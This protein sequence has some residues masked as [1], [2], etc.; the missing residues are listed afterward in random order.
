[1]TVFPVVLGTIS[2]FHFSTVEEYFVGGLFLPVFNAVTDIS[3][4]YCTLFA[5]QYWLGNEW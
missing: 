4:V 3:P 1:M 5:S 2:V